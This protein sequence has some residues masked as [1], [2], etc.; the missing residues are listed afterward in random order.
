MQQLVADGAANNGFGGLAPLAGERLVR[1]TYL[2]E[3]G[4]S[5]QEEDVVVAGV[6][7]DGDRQLAAVEKHLR[8]LTIKHIPEPDRRGFIFHATNIFSGTK[9]YKNRELWPWERR[10]AILNDLA[11][12][13]DLF[14]LP[15]AFGIANKRRI[16]GEVPQA[17]AVVLDL[18]Y[19]ACAFANATQV[20]ERYF[21]RD[22]PD[23]FTIIIAE[24]RQSVRRFMKEVQAVLQ[25]RGSVDLPE[26][27]LSLFGELPYHHIRDTLHWAAKHESPL[28]Q[29]ADTCAFLLRGAA[30]K[31]PRADQFVERLVASTLLYPEGTGHGFVRL[32]EP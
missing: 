32:P 27:V 21:R 30:A 28:L 24:D 31:H 6:I 1:L 23:E 8:E 10:A 7:V 3:G 15:I 12:I 19:H 5:A 2:D 17:S 16:D 26:D 25:G 18:V 11:D 4:I 22:Y 13:P 9:Y 14:Q 20:V 29:V